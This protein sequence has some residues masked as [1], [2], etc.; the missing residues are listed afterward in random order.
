MDGF[1]VLTLDDVIDRC[2]LVITATGNRGVVTAAQM[3]KMKHQ[4]IVGNI[5][6]FDNEI[7]MAGL[8]AFPGI[9]REQVKPQVDL[10]RFPDG[11]AIIVLSEGRLLNL[12]N[13]TGHPSFVM[14]N[15]FTNQVMAQLELYRSDTSHEIG[16]DD[17][18]EA[19][20]REGG[21]AAPRRARRPAHDA[22][23]RPGRLPRHRRRRALQA[24]DLPLLAAAPAGASRQP[25]NRSV[26]TPVR[27]NGSRA[28]T[29]HSVRNSSRNRSRPIFKKNELVGLAR[30]RGQRVELRVGRRGHVHDDADLLVGRAERAGPRSTRR[31]RGRSTP[32]SSHHRAEPAERRDSGSPCRRGSRRARTPRAPRP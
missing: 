13:A 3:A 15:S 25:A 28:R 7:D 12:G 14:S 20:R 27:P 9:V 6:H 8:T 4:C 10:W 31:R 11:H 26:S 32:A 1:E 18:A 2:D 21:S 19:P 23:R 24:R 29:N 22:Q 16:G 17:A 30:V 5:G